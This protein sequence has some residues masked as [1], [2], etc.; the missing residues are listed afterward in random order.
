MKSKEA[1][2][3]SLLTELTSK[4]TKDSQLKANN[5]S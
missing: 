3:N 2:I 4:K 1:T 5:Q